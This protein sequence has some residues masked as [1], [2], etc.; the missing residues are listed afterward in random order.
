LVHRVRSLAIG[1]ALATGLMGCMTREAMMPVHDRQVSPAPIQWPV[2]NP[3]EADQ[4]AARIPKRI[5]TYGD[6]D[7]AAQIEAATPKIRV[8]DLNEVVSTGGGVLIDWLSNEI[9]DPPPSAVTIHAGNVTTLDYSAKQRPQAP[10]A[11][12]PARFWKTLTPSPGWQDLFKPP[13]QFESKGQ[14]YSSSNPLADRILNA[15]EYATIP[16]LHPDDPPGTVVWFGGI[17]PSWRLE[18]DSQIAFVRRGFAF[19]GAMESVLSSFA[20]F[21]IRLQDVPEDPAEQ[22]GLMFRS[23]FEGMK[24]RITKL[25]IY[26]NA[27]QAGENL[28]KE[29]SADV[30]ASASGAEPV[31]AWVEQQQP[32]LR[33]RPLIVVGCSG[34]VPAA[35]AFASR[36]VDRL[37]GLIF[38]GGF[39]DFEQLLARTDLNDGEATIAWRDDTPLPEQQRQ[40]TEAFQ[41]NCTVDPGRLA[42][43]I[44]TDRVLMVQGRFD[45]LVPADLSDRLWQSLGQPERWKF[46]GGHRLLFFRLSAY[47]NDL[48]EWA[49]ARTKS[50][51]ASRLAPPAPH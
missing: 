43:A 17:G 40:F 39:E 41:A 7:D 34:G 44:P 25:A 51:E 32:S 4:F 9:P 19:V 2:W 21:R 27:A 26:Q 22:L 35:M 46:F 42:R 16:S 23:S 31:L 5:P 36:H 45:T 38:V 14:Y 3:Q 50:F 33:S 11:D 1:S 8:L 48:A 29:I 47:S 20:R 30:I 49:E 24:R 12:S 13:L 6:L 10:A 37:A 28:G 15:K 18:L